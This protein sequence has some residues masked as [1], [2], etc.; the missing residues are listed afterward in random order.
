MT[1]DGNWFRKTRRRVRRAD[2]GRMWNGS[3]KESQELQGFYARDS[4]RAKTRVEIEIAVPS[5]QLYVLR[6]WSGHSDLVRVP[7]QQGM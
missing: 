4:W 3:Q 2:D 5:T 7:V 1:R 6:S